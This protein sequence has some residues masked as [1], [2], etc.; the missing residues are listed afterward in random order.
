MATYFAPRSDIQ[1]ANGNPYAGAKAY[2]YRTGTTTTKA[3]YSNEAMT[4][5]HAQ[6]VV[7]DASGRWPAIWMATDEA[8]SVVITSSADVPIY[9]ADPHRPAISANE[10]VQLSAVVQRISSNPLMFGGV[11]DG[12][13]ND[14]EAVQDAIDNASGTVDLLGLTYKINSQLL[15]PSN[16]RIING[17]LDFSDCSD[18]IWVSLAGDLGDPVFLTSTIVTS[19]Q[20]ELASTT[21][22]T[23]G[24]TLWLTADYNIDID[25]IGTAK[26][27]ELVRIKSVGTPCVL[28]RNTYTT[29]PT[30]S[31]A[32]IE[33][34]DPVHDV[35]FRD[36]LVTGSFGA[37][38]VAIQAR[39][40][41]DLEFH[42]CRFS[43]INGPSMELLTCQNVKIAQ[44][45]TFGAPDTTLGC[46]VN[47]ADG[48]QDIV[49][50]G[51]TADYIDRGIIIGEDGASKGVIR[52]VMVGN[53]SFTGIQTAAVT[54]HRQASY[55]S[56]MG[57]EFHHCSNLCITSTG[58]KLTALGNHV[59]GNGVDGMIFVLYEC[60][61][62]DNNTLTEGDDFLYISNNRASTSE[63]SLLE[64]SFT[65]ALAKDTTLVSVHDNVGFDD[66]IL[67]SNGSSSHDLAELS[68]CD[69]GGLDVISLDISGGNSIERLQISGNSMINN[70]G[71]ILITSSGNISQTHIYGNDMGGTIELEEVF[72]VIVESNFC[73]GISISKTSLG[74][75]VGG[76]VIRGNMITTDGTAFPIRV[77]GNEHV[78]TRVIISNNNIT[79][80][81]TSEGI[82]IEMDGDASF[83]I[84]N[85]IIHMTGTGTSYPIRILAG[86][87][88]IISNSTITGNSIY[89]AVA[90]HG[91]YIQASG[92]GTYKSVVLNANAIEII[93]GGTWND[94]RLSGAAVGSIDTVTVDGNC[95]AEGEYGLLIAN[96][97]RLVYD[98]NAHRSHS[99]GDVSGT[100][101]V[102][103][104]NA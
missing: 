1:D 25:S 65:P 40:A 64:I 31:Q 18:S 29:Y 3:V 56:I 59:R 55:V 15:V 34:L 17:T 76:I 22:L 16:R 21:G 68:I 48:S 42:N 24:D 39:Y 67:T 83:I 52:N 77:D 70:G 50:L 9:S 95:F 82:S 58:S 28:T 62:H 44:C 98:S 101:D 30:G 2:F 61:Q 33:K 79:S 12:V 102:S 60:Q 7:A 27:G 85:N 92:T 36:V 87:P 19:D 10:F 66:C 4:I 100:P 89:N 91:I 88:A 51:C 32:Q 5:P 71:E 38:S 47:I 90:G 57:S 104:D 78:T 45:T 54:L 14:Y 86:S 96:T 13:T 75:A 11:G 37:D 72:N 80:V 23:S 99:T 49:I 43:G 97:V 69:N 46:M 94:V 93:N 74:E 8:Y 53:C 41:R 103:G 20:L 63:V 35:V 81:N 73:H 26:P 84:S 6:P